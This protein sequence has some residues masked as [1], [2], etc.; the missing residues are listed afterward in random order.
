LTT[1]CKTDPGA[2]LTGTWS[3]DGTIVFAE[4]L[5]HQPLMRVP[6]GGGT[7]VPIATETAKRVNALLAP[8]FLNDSKMLYYTAVHGGDLHLR[9][10]DFAKSTDDD[11]GPIESRT[12][13][14]GDTILFARS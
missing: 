12:E 14:I 5:L 1:I 8:R 11:L 13:I 9:L 3:T 6:A 7:P 10:L 2:L 4:L